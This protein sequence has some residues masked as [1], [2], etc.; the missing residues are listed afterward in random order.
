MIK[1]SSIVIALIVLSFLSANSQTTIIL[2]PAD[3]LGKDALLHGLPS[4]ANSNYGSS[5][6][7]PASAWTFGG[8]PGVVRSVLDFDLSSIPDGATINSAYLSLYAWDSNGGLGQHSTLS[9]SNDCWLRRIISPWDESTVTWNN[10]PATTTTNQVTLAESTIPSQDYLNIDA[11]DMVR[12]MINNPSTS[13]G[14]LIRLQDESYYR[15][16]NFASSDHMDKALH[17][18]LVVSYSQPSSIGEITNDDFDFSLFPNPASNSISVD[19]NKSQQKG[20]YL[21][22]ISLSGQVKY[23]AD[24]QPA[25]SIDVS[26]YANG[27]YFVKVYSDDS[28]STRKFIICR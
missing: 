8:A 6:Q 28:V 23:R 18:K 13:F 21:Q 19:L 26:D 16:L 3:S 4:E 12:D 27:V 22:I 15:Q 20:V 10:Q 25:T 9:G 14:F 5:A 24:I 2:Q 7:L 11:T 17:P 1:R